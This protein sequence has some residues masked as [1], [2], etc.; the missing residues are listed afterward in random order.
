MPIYEYRCKDCGTVSEILQGVTIK[1]V[2]VKCSN[3]GGTNLVKLISTHA[4][5]SK[6]H[7]DLPGGSCCG[8]EKKELSDCCVPGSCC[9]RYT[10]GE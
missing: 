4:G 6:K 10:I 5:G 8:G 3:C 7:G 2:P 9:G 1:E